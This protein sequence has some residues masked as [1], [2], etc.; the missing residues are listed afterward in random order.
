MSGIVRF[1]PAGPLRGSYTPPPDKSIS[2]RAAL[3]GAMADEPVTVRNY[4]DSED[5]RSTLDA[6]R[7]LGAGIEEEGEGCVVSGGWACMRRSRPRA[8]C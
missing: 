8:A 3:I 1:D 5:T 6:L 2:H 4:L 7:T